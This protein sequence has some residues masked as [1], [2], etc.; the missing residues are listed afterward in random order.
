MWLRRPVNSGFS[1]IELL[2]VSTLSM[3]LLGGAL[4]AYSTFST[5]QSR[6]DSGNQVLSDL[7][8]AQQRSRSG[9]QPEACNSLGG[10]QVWNTGGASNE[11]RIAVKCNSPAQLMET[12]VKTLR[13]NEVFLTTFNVVFPPLPGPAT[14]VPATIDIGQSG[15][16]LKY[17]FTIDTQGVV[18]QG[19]FV[20]N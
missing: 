17:R 2:V 11:Y 5:R 18:H 10:Y 8:A 12:E 7:R 3:V 20:T 6:L 9:E 4:A 16:T 13:E 14:G 1:L 19:A 15:D